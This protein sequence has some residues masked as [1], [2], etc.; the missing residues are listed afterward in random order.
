MTTSRLR[1]PTIQYTRPFLPSPRLMRVDNLRTS[2]AGMA[3]TLFRITAQTFS[4]RLIVPSRLLC[5]TT[6][7][8]ARPSLAQTPISSRTIKVKQIASAYKN[9]TLAVSTRTATL[10]TANTPSPS[11]DVIDKWPLGVAALFPACP[12]ARRQPLMVDHIDIIILLKGTTARPRAFSNRV[13]YPPIPTAK[14]F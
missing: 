6:F 1:T 9:T 2:G 3:R 13:L 11:I 10:S 8:L 7:R 5:P 12:H 4:I 14:A